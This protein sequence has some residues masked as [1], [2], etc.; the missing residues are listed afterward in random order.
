[1]KQYK[2][3]IAIKESDVWG[4][5]FWE[6]VLKE[7]LSGITGLKE[8]IDQIFEDSNLFIGSDRKLSDIIKLTEYKEL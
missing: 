6:D 1:M 5:E 8:A 4:D 2:F 3:E 7:D